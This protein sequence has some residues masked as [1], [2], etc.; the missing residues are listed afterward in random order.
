MYRKIYYYHYIDTR[1][2]NM[3][4]ELEGVHLVSDELLTSGNVD[5]HV[6]RV[7]ERRGRYPDVD[8]YIINLYFNKK[9]MT[10]QPTNHY[11]IHTIPD[12][13]QWPLILLRTKL[14]IYQE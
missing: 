2:T 1:P 12:S 3:F 8:L 10:I 9:W 7:L 14:R 6:A 5:A 4:S 13:M 11:D